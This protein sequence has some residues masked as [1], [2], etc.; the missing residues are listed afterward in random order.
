MLVTIDILRKRN[1]KWKWALVIFPLKQQGSS[2]I[3]QWGF[4]CI[5][6]C[7]CPLLNLP[8]GW[9]SASLAAGT[10][11]GA[12]GEELSCLTWTCLGCGDGGE[13]V[14]AY[15]GKLIVIQWG[16]GS[17]I[18]SLLCTRANILHQVYRAVFWAAELG[19]RNRTVFPNTLK[20]VAVSC[21]S[22]GASDL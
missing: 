15:L 3:A 1:V 9:H 8:A 20:S 6:W 22:L 4:R 14:T 2:G 16:K 17:V 12:D 10:S 21:F 11:A 18:F 7:L 13:T 19:K 5:S